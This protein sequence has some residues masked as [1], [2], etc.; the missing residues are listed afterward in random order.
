MFGANSVVEAERMVSAGMTPLEVL[1]SATS[2][3][4]IHLGSKDLG[5]V[6]I[7]TSADLVLFRGDPAKSID[8]WKAPL[9]VV[10][11]GRLVHR[12]AEPTAA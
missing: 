12:H 8:N 1:R 5:V 4:A 7:G 3:A 11:Q 10:A 6:S 2:C 9:A